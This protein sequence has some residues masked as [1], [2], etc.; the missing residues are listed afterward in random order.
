M[1]YFPQKWIK[2]AEVKQV[3]LVPPSSAAAERAFSLLSAP[4]SGQRDSALADCLQ[5]SVMLQY[6]KRWC[7]LVYTILIQ[8]IIGG[9]RTQNCQDKLIYFLAWYFHRYSSL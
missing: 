6:N 4:F 8:A 1:V 3:L 2:S 5:A 7:W 9:E